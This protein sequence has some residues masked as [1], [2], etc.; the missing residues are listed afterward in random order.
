MTVALSIL[1]GISVV[2]FFIWLVQREYRAREK[3]IQEAFAGRESLAPDAFYDH[4]FGGL[5]IESEDIHPTI[6][7]SAAFSHPLITTRKAMPNAR[8]VGCRG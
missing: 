4:Y 8:P 1:V 2:A 6:S 7:G 5:G 3:K